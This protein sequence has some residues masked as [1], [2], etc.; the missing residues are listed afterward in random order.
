MVFLSDTTSA[1]YL[2]HV[3]NIVQCHELY[4]HLNSYHSL[5]SNTIRVQRSTARLILLYR[6][7]SQHTQHC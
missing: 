5:Q 2:Q 7:P 4:L 6:M 3:S 1:A